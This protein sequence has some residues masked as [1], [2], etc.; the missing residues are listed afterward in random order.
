MLGTLKSILQEQTAKT[1]RSPATMRLL[2]NPRVQQTLLKVINLRADN[3]Q[4]MSSQVQEFARSNDL[5]TREDVVRLRR[6]VRDLEAT[7]ASL[8]QQLAKD[9]VGRALVSQLQQLVQQHG[10]RRDMCQRAICR[11]G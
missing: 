8:T 2:S 1:L 10:V 6:T 9:L 11:G 4:K 5:V 7:V 3:R